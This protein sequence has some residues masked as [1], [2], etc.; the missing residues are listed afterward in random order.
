MVFGKI[1]AY[2]NALKV[3]RTDDGIVFW[4]GWGFEGDFLEH[5]HIIRLWSIKLYLQH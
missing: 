3:Q 1:I 4:E 5:N 2:R